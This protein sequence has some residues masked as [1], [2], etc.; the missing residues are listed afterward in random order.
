MKSEYPL[1]AKAEIFDAEGVAA[2]SVK[3][4]ELVVCV[5]RKVTE[6]ATKAIAKRRPSKV[7]FLDEAFSG[8]D[9]LKANVKM[10]FE[11]AGVKRFETV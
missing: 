3:D 11:S 9:Q 1:T 2:Y 7:I 4:D 10:N 6:E 5:E 8:N